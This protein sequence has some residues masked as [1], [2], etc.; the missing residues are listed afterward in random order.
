MVNIQVTL[1]VVV[2]GREAVCS[3]LE[4]ADLLGFSQKSTWCQLYCI[5]IY[6]LLVSEW[7][8]WTGS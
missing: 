1:N 3:I 4:T 7:N 6:I 2:G 5:D 8:G